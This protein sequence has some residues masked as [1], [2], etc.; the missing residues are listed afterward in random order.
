MPCPYGL[1]L[2]LSGTMITNTPQGASRSDAQFTS[3]QFVQ[4]PQQILAG[5]A[6]HVDVEKIEH[7]HR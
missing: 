3:I 7:Q 4:L 6:V 2:G 1:F 5:H